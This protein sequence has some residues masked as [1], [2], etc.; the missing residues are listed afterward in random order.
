[1]NALYLS[2]LSGYATGLQACILRERETKRE[3]LVYDMVKVRVKVKKEVWKGAVQG[4]GV[5]KAA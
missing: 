1:M 5:Y 2:G 3:R 4:L